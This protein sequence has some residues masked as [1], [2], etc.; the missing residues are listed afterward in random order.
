MKVLF[1]TNNPITT[2]LSDWLGER[3]DVVI[4]QDILS[5]A[6]LTDMQPDL[7]VSYSYQHI[8]KADVLASLP[9]R[10]I[11]LHIS[12]LPYNRGADP[13]AWSF[14]DDTKKGVSIHLI[15]PG[16]DTGPLLAQ[17]EIAFD[18]RRETLGSSYNVLQEEIQELFCKHWEGLNDG[19]IR[20]V[21]QVGKGSY[22]RAQ[23]F[24]E[25]KDGLMG[26]EGFGVP[27]PLFKERYRLTQVVMGKDILD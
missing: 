21:A 4:W 6:N 24:K 15:D 22:H 26:K 27:I 13:N 2:P 14:L 9:I 1:L 11:N 20:A 17:K 3:A 5:I 10:F 12:L 18:E 8:L 16:I 7:V 25:I 23:Q 19:T